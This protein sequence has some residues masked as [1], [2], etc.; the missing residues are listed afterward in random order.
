MVVNTLC[1]R[2]LCAE[3]C[4]SIADRDHFDEAFALPLTALHPSLNNT[5]THHD[6]ELSSRT[7][8]LGLISRLHT[9]SC[10]WTRQVFEVPDL[11][12]EKKAS[13]PMRDIR[14]AKLTL[15]ICVGESGDR[16]QKAAK[17][18]CDASRFPM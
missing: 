16:L 10:L 12:N 8:V 6:Q 3:T 13:N 11:Q 2:Q 7:V 9:R 4:T 14:V 17:V 18:R 1:T 5:K 15:N